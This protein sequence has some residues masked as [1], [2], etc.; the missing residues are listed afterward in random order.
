METVNL[1]ARLVVVEHANSVERELTLLRAQRAN[2]VF[3]GTN[4]I[5]SA[6][7]LSATHDFTWLRVNR[8]PSNARIGEIIFDRARPA[9]SVILCAFQFVFCRGVPRGG[10]W[11]KVQRHC[12]PYRGH[13][14]LVE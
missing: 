9:F 6:F 1:V 11:G 13:P 14:R 8:T 3:R 5:Q 4:E 10:D 2:F 7:K 12:S